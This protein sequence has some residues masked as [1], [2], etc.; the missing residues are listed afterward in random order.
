MQLQLP[1]TR[2]V[3]NFAMVL[4]ALFLPF[5]AGAAVET[6][7]GVGVLATIILAGVFCFLATIGLG[8]RFGTWRALFLAVVPFGLLSTLYLVARVLGPVEEP[9]EFAG[10]IITL[11]VTLIWLV[12]IAVGVL[13]RKAVFRPSLLFQ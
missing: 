8:V 7:P 11:I 10:A 12:G 13:M 6:V 3:F 9:F 2:L 4:G 5:F 1:G